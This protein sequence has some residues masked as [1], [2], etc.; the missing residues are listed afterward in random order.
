MSQIPKSPTKIKNFVFILLGVLGIVLILVADI[1]HFEKNPLEEGVPTFDMD[2]LV[3]SFLIFVSVLAIA[4]G[5]IGTNRPSI[6]LLPRN[7]SPS[8]NRV[9]GRR[10]IAKMGIFTT[11]AFSVFFLLLALTWSRAFNGLSRED[12][13][14]EWVSALLL[15]SAA[16][17]FL[18]SVIK[19]SR[20][21]KGQTTFKALLLFYFLLLFVIA[22]EE[23]SWLQR[24]FHFESPAAF[25]NNDQ[26][27]FN[28]HN[29]FTGAAENLYYGGSFFLL[30]AL[31]FLGLLY[32]DKIPNHFLRMAIP[33]PYIMVVAAAAFS[34][35]FDMWD[36]AFTQITFFGCIIVLAVTAK[37][38][39]DKVE[40]NMIWLLL[41]YLILQ[42]L[43]FLANPGIIDPIV[44]DWTL[45]EYKE[46]FIP[47][48]F[49]T[50]SVD[51][52][53]QIRKRA[54][55]KGR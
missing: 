2:H 19:F 23:I 42:Q 51:T 3:R 5:F 18:A 25:V 55:V 15:F 45:T 1:F 20:F 37:F 40:K 11:Y 9:I 4:R 14:L 6:P 30:I 21:L 12:R 24:V 52:Y 46:F 50:F 33:R 17:I 7:G 26:M 34:F 36:I 47:V 22:M 54:F 39:T 8:P 49:F 13:I 38:V 35:N 53:F 41:C 32:A 43:V 10:E 27:E 31:P 16:A 44:R 48:A 29:F 28:F